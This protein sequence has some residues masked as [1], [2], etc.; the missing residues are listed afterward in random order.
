MSRGADD[1]LA[2][3]CR[4][5]DGPE[6]LRLRDGAQE[7]GVLKKEGIRSQDSRGR[8]TPGLSRWRK[9]DSRR[10]S[11]VDGPEVEP[12][13][14]PWLISASDAEAF[15]TSLVCDADPGASRAVCS[16]S[17]IVSGMA[18]SGGVPGI[19]WS[20]RLRFHKRSHVKERKVA[21]GFGVRKEPAY[22]RLRGGREVYAPVNTMVNI[23]QLD[24]ERRGLVGLNL[25][26][27]IEL[28]L[29]CDK[30]HPKLHGCRRQHTGRH[31]V[32]WW[33]R[34]VVVLDSG[35]DGELIW[36]EIKLAHPP[37]LDMHQAFGHTLLKPVARELWVDHA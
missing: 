11:K 10:P 16:V 29:F 9:N 34:Q 27:K 32:H 17:K 3:W 35:E 12:S 37:C 15:V 13:F 4:L 25:A 2:H 5:L 36:R 21:Q 30:P 22:T 18:T 26:P 28:D 6:M 1:D 19:E 24:G 8:S 33:R 23:T 7:E 14:D 31:D 20:R